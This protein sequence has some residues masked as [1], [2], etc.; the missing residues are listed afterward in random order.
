MYLQIFLTDALFPYKQS[1]FLCA[2]MKMLHFMYHKLVL[3]RQGHGTTSVK[4]SQD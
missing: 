3:L 1:T 2:W 4:F